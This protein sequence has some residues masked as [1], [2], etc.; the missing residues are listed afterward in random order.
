V[1][2]I[3]KVWV[4]AQIYEED[5]AYLP[6][7]SHDPKTG[8]VSRK[9]EVIATTRAFPGRSFKGNLSFIFP[10]VDQDTRTLTVRFELDNRDHELRPGMSATVTLLLT[11]ADLPDLPAGQGLRIDDG[12]I[13]AVPDSS[14]ID[15]G[16]EKIVYKEDLPGVFDGVRVVLGSRMSGPNGEV[17]F[18]VLEG[19]KPN[20]LVVTAGSFLIDAETR[21]NPA[22]GSIYIGGSGSGSSKNS[23]P[24]IAARPSD[25]EDKD[26]KIRIALSKLL[27]AD[28][29]IAEAQ[30]WCPILEN[31]RL[32]SME[33]PVK[34]MLDGHRVFVCCKQCVDKAKDN[35]SATNA[36]VAQLTEKV[37]PA[38]SAPRPPTL[39]AKI[40]A[41]LAKL[42][43]DDRKLAEAQRFCPLTNGPLG[44]MG[45]PPKLM[46]EGQPVFTC[47]ED[48]NKDVIAKPD[49][50][51]KEVN[52]FKAQ[53]KKP[54]K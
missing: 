22:M 10:H 44:S 11:A 29:T 52:E 33:V 36:R 37:K 17:F 48:C 21:L 35:P 39:E 9:L 38:M 12:K 50:M 15:T 25:P 6:K 53:A 31:S 20:E 51:L 30:K 41:N 26:A 49:E 4:Q 43:P 28:R 14:V 24:V 2:D 32:G 19:L 54:K 45:V 27:P 47:C 40:R 34:L 23:P 16:K 18:P 5:L 8:G 13:L 7:G 42:A 46:I 1:A 3:S